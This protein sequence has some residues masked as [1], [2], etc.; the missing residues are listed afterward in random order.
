MAK[1]SLTPSRR[2]MLAGLAAA[3]VAGLPALAH[4]VAE[5]DPVLTALE[6]LGRARA[7]YE[8]QVGDDCVDAVLDVVCE[9]MRNAEVALYSTAPTTTAGAAQ[10]LRVI[11][12]YLSEEGNLYD[13]YL[14][15]VL[16]NAIRNAAALL[17]QEVRS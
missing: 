2:A 11:A 15:P 6:G 16:G 9:D 3:P 17:E 13:I 8:Q 10:L 4:V 1:H 12:D 5:P 7:A 14:E